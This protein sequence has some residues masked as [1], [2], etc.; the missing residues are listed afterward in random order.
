MIY[1]NALKILKRNFDNPI[2][3]MYLK[4][5][6]LCHQLQMKSYK[7]Y[8]CSG[9]PVFKSLTRNYSIIIS[10]QIISSIHKFILKIQ[11]ILESPELKDHCHL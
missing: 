3:T 6:Q 5:K 7:K 1:A 8:N 10:I 9:L 2:V 11:Q 4:M